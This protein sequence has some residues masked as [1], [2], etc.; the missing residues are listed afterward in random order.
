MKKHETDTTQQ[1][2]ASG[3]MTGYETKQLEFHFILK[4]N[5][6]EHRKYINMLPDCDE[7]GV[8]PK[9][10]FDFW[11]NIVRLS[12]QGGFYT[13]KILPWPDVA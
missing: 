3:A 2:S 4:H 8:L 7:N 11:M 5:G 13:L 12:T 1:S 10:R 6:V 9:E